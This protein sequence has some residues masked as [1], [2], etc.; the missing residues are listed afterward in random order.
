M[1][2]EVYGQTG[3]LLPMDVRNYSG[4]LDLADVPAGTYRLTAELRYGNN[5]RVQDQRPIEVVEEGGQKV[6]RVLDSRDVPP[7]VVTF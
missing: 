7:T 3:V 2:S 5:A 6:I 1:D 4:T